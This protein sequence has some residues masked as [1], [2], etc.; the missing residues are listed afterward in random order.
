MAIKDLKC[1]K[2]P[3]EID[4]RTGDIA[5][6]K[7]GDCIGSQ[8]LSILSTEPGERPMQPFLGLR[9]QALGVLAPVVTATDI[10]DQLQSW[11][12]TEARVHVSYDKDPSKFEEGVLDVEVSYS[13]G[14][15][16]QSIIL[17][18]SDGFQV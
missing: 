13:D 15:A 17:G 5:M 9:Q 6:V 10:E 1:I 14:E 7:G 2:I 12:T 3:M 4:P 8:I 16:R 18:I 11:V